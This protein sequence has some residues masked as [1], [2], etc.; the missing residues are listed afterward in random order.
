[1]TVFYTRLWSGEKGMTPA[2]ALREAQLSL[3]R[4]PEM[5]PSWAKERG[6]TGKVEKIEGYQPAPKAVGAAATTSHPKL[7]AGFVLS[8]LGQ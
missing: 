5:I 7:W 4:H 8:G 1:M 3:Y 2:K 6:P